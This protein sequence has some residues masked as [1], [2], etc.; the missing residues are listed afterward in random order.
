MSNYTWSCLAFSQK[1]AK[2]QDCTDRSYSEHGR[3]VSQRWLEGR[4][5]ADTPGGRS[6]GGVLGAPSSRPGCWQCCSE[7][8]VP[9]DM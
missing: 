6:Q 1:S 8:G 5:P 2:G 9:A 3:S 7:A 4:S